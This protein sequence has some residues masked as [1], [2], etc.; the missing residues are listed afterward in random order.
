MHGVP[1][2]HITFFMMMR[3]VAQGCR[4]KIAEI[5]KKFIS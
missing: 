5:E 4:E 2:H 3:E 1:H